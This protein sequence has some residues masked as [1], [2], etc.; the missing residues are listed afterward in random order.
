MVD[1]K[2]EVDINMANHDIIKFKIVNNIYRTHTNVID[3][4]KAQNFNV[5]DDA[6]YKTPESIKLHSKARIAFGDLY[7]M[8]CKIRDG[9]HISYNIYLLEQIENMNPLVKEA[10]EKLCPEL[11]RYLNYHTSNI[12]RE[13]IRVSNK[14]NDYKIA[15]LLEDALPFHKPIPVSEIKNKLQDIYS[16]LK[17]ERNAKATDLKTWFQVQESTK[18]IDQKNTACITILRNNFINRSQP[19]TE[20]E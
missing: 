20:S 2:V 10:Y 8:Y 14:G 11:V 9:R 15:K 17:L 12:R 16:L 13:I 5:T 3:E 19:E 4:L 18:R 7:E 1:N 6:S